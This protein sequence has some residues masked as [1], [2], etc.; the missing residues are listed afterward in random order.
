MIDVNEMTRHTKISH[1]VVVSECGQA[2]ASE[3][4]QGRADNK[5]IANLILV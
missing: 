3:A 4:D 5:R 2:Q 1:F